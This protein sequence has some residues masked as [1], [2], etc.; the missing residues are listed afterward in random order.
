MDV[1]TLTIFF[2]ISLKTPRTNFGRDIEEIPKVVEVSP[3]IIIT[4][5]GI[6][7]TEDMG[8]RENR[9]NWNN[10]G[11]RGNNHISRGGNFRGRGEHRNETQ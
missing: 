1:G 2:K 6:T 5:E 8:T 3:E 7:A 4:I 10:F 9:G 11:Y